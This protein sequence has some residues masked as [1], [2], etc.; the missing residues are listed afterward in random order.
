M[1][2]LGS[3][4]EAL[5]TNIPVVW[6]LL[7]I[8]KDSTFKVKTVMTTF[9]EKIGYVSNIWSHLMEEP[10]GLCLNLDTILNCPNAI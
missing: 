8:S 1:T 5:G 2:R 3:F 7:A 9:W 6:Q 10:I 4:R